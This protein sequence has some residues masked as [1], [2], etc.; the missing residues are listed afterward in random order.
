MSDVRLQ[1]AL[2]RSG[3]ASRRKAEELIRQG[4]VTVNG[5]VATL[6]MAVDLDRDDVRV[7]GRRVRPVQEAWI[8]LHKPVGAVVTRSDPEG[9]PTVFSLV[10]RH[11][12]LVYVGRLDFMTSGLL[13]LTTDGEAAHRL[14]HPRFAVERTYRALVRGRSLGEIRRR[15]AATTV[16]DGRPVSIVRYRVRER[17]Q[18]ATDLSLTLAE[19]RNRIV[20]RVCE[21]WGLR[22][23]RLSRLSYGPIQLGRLPVGQWRYLSRVERAHL[24]EV[25]GTANG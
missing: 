3:V 9:R 12:G 22:V 15:L 2:A 8:A 1:R 21:Q 23:Q 6:G 11:P 25:V 24:A 16:V 18:G 19:G 5:V 14:T 20:R 7:R 13:L 4:R 17:G 10:P